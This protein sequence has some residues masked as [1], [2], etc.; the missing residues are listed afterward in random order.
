MTFSAAACV[1]SSARMRMASSI[2]FA[3]VFPLDTCA[4]LARRLISTRIS[5]VRALLMICRLRSRL[6][7]SSPLGTFRWCGTWAYAS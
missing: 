5:R 1:A 2:G 6:A 3:E 4:V 7:D